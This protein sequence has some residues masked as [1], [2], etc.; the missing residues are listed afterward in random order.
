VPR[1]DD[2]VSSAQGRKLF[3]AN[4]GDSRAVLAERTADGFAAIDLTQDQTP[5]RC[6]TGGQIIPESRFKQFTYYSEGDCQLPLT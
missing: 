3:V 4:V 6:C 1:A 5:Y 2:P